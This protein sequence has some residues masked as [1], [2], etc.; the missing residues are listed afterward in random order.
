MKFAFA[1]VAALVV[2]LQL[3]DGLPSARTLNEGCEPGISSTLF[4]KRF[5]PGPFHNYFLLFRR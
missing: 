2:L 3:S 4:S 1:T 5:K